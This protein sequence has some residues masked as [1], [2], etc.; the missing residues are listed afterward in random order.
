VIVV[1]AALVT[2]LAAC[3]QK[4]STTGKAETPEAGEPTPAGGAGLSADQ[5]GLMGLET[6]LLVAAPV[7]RTETGQATVLAHDALAQSLADVQLAMAAVAQSDA[8]L[9]RAEGLASTPGALGEDTVEMTRRQARVD[10]LQLQLAQRRQQ[11]QF[12]DL[13]RTVP[14]QLAEALADGGAKLVRIVFSGS[15]TGHIDA[16]AIRFTALDSAER[17]RSWTAR[18]AWPAPAEAGVPGR[19]LYAVIEDPGVAEGS[20]LLASLTLRSGATGVRV[21]A[22][23]VVTHDGQLWCYV[24][25]GEG[26]FERRSV[27]AAHA[28]VEGYAVASGF[29]VGERVVIRGAGLLLAREFGQTEGAP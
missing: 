2:A 5:V 24:Q 28:A 27:D 1:M 22:A 20:R 3:G 7:E 29:K 17:S 23:A 26:Q 16:G 13:V 15:P 19:N 14:G 25:T 18:V 10:A 9:K 8:A 6:Q 11:A 12:G 4:P 21:P